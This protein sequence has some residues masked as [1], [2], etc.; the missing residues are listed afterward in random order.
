MTGKETKG[1]FQDSLKLADSV[2]KGEWT[3]E[4][5]VQVGLYTLEGEWKLEAVVHISLCI[6]RMN[7]N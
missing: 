5:V 7:G 6:L 4:A 2:P 3:L 1:V